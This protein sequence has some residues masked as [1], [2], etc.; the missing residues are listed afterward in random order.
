MYFLNILNFVFIFTVFLFQ[1]K[2]IYSLKLIVA[3][4]FSLLCDVYFQSFFSSFKYQGKKIYT[5]NLIIPLKFLFTSWFLFSKKLLMHS[6][7]V[8][9]KISYFEIMYQ[10]HKR[11]SFVYLRSRMCVNIL[12]YLM[13]VSSTN[14]I[15]IDVSRK[16]C[17]LLVQ[18]SLKK[19]LLIKRKL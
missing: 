19:V 15:S 13:D 12:K 9:Q 2:K 4:N 11:Y 10:S 8:T 16:K 5:P 3:L 1:C 18:L 17:F 6:N 14:F 7:L